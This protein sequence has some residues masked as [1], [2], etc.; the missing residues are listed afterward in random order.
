MK[1][2]IYLDHAA[3]TPLDSRVLETMRPYFSDVF[4]NPSSFH[5][6]GMRAKEA[7]TEAR[8]RIAK[9]LG[10]HEDE[11][12]F[13]SGGTESDN[14][15]V[16]GVPRYFMNELK[17][18]HGPE[19]V[20]HVIVS[21]V[22]HHAV[23]EPLIWLQRRKEIE[24]TTVGV[25]RYGQVN[26]KDIVAALKPTTVLVTVMM[27]NNEIGTIQP[28]ADIGRELLKWRKEQKTALPYLH[29]DACQAT[30]FLEIDVEKL[31]ADLLTLNGSKIYGPKGVGALY[32]RRGVKF[33]PLIIGGG[34]ERNLRSGTENVP[35]IIGLAKALELAQA[36]REVE[37]ARLLALREKLAA[38]LLAIPKTILNGHPTER[39]PNSVNVSFI[40][41]EGEAAVLYLDAE[42]VMASTGSACASTSLDPSHVIL[43]TGLSYEAAHGSIRFTLGHA[44]TEEDVDYVI[45][46][47]PAIV[48][49]LRMMSPVNLDMK[50]FETH[51][52]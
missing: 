2:L 8:G 11:I 31:H 3:T 19:V 17:K 26:P 36:D 50:Y 1:R 40:D 43:A 10:G 49:R 28:I 38:G 20:P 25:D 21:A 23:I 29:T 47:M 35:G 42:G 27:A 37:S 32:V 9:L 30:G 13:T 48:E 46:I 41:I 33:Q 24:L 51:T 18:V 16:L 12:L 22:E 7:V 34:Q 6:L 52:N 14:M 44:T 15:A 39:L 45:K 5:T 4:G